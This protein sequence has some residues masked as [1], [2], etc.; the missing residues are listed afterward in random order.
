MRRSL[1]W[2]SWFLS[3]SWESEWCPSCD[4]EPAHAGLSDRAHELEGRDAGHV[5]RHRIDE[6]VDLHATDLGRVVVDQLDV[7]I[8]LGLGVHEL[9]CRIRG[10]S[11]PFSMARTN[12]M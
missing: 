1:F 4:V 11:G 3:G 12:S 5:V 7:G 2:P 10:A 9:P 6:Q 8:E